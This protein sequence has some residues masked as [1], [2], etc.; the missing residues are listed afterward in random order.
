MIIA[1]VL[2]AA[3]MDRHGLAHDAPGVRILAVERYIQPCA[4]GT[5][6][7]ANVGDPA[8]VRREGA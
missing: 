8:A 2:K 7:M 4:V 5:W 1:S 6:L 3:W